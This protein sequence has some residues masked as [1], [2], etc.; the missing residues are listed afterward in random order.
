M[1]SQYHVIWY[2]Q[3]DVAMALPTEVFEIFVNFSHIV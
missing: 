2:C 3:C 1:S